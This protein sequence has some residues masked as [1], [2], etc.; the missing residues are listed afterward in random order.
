MEQSLIEHLMDLKKCVVRVLMILIA[1]FVACIYFSEHIFDIIRSP[2]LPYL[3]TTGGLVFTAPIDKFMAHIKVSFIASAVITSP[4]WLHQVWM[5]I[6]PGLYK[7]E[8]KMGVAF[9][10][11]GTM[12]FLLGVLF[13]YQ[14]VY[15]AAF[16]YLL[17][18]GGDIDKP[19]ITINEYL[20]FFIT[21]T[22]VFGLAFEMPL[23][24]VIMAM[25]GIVD[26]K[27]LRAKRR[28]AIML[29]AIFAAVVTPPDAVSM[30]A[31]LAPLLFL[32]ELSIILV[33]VIV[34]KRAHKIDPAA[35]A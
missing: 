3:E 29:M 27:F 12:L 19:M 32:Y 16:K 25:A 24:I 22:L 4:L 28:L 9:I 34:Q 13:V 17:H 5:F 7:H 26:D 18:F 6:A 11:F 21:T 14:I 20:G 10:F 30:L 23:V 33:R 8:K 31:M 35:R 15:P 1:G 2:I